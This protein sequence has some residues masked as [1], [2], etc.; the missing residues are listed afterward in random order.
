ME[1]PY[2]QET[3]GERMSTVRHERG[4]SRPQRHTATTHRAGKAI[5][6]DNDDESRERIVSKWQEV[7]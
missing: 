1:L 2:D 7:D 6:S 5:V 3:L 4:Q